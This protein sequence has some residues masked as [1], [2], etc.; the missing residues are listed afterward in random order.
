VNAEQATGGGGADDEDDVLAT[1]KKI[2][3]NQQ[4]EMQQEPLVKVISK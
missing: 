2:K 3:R 1:R 4:I